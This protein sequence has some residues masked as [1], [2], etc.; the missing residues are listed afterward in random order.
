[1]RKHFHMIGSLAGIALVSAAVAAHA[2]TPANDPSARLKQV[3]P[4]DV[5]TRVLAVIAKAK[6]VELPTEALENRALKFA[7]KGVNGDSIAKSVADQEE[8]MEHVR[9]TLQ[10]ARGQKPS[11][12]EID[13]AAEAVRKGVDGSK[14]S[15]LAKSA[16]SGR[17]LVV[18]LYVIGSLVERGLPSDS[19][20][21]RVEAKLKARASDQ[22]LEKLPGELPA[23]ANASHGN[24]PAE[25]GRALAE[26][27]RPGSASGAGQSGGSAGGPPAGVPAN[28]G[29]K[30]ATPPGLGH[31]PTTP[32]PKKP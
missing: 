24:Q 25:T 5:A 11:G 6:S 1:M 19:A 20:L 16:P 3:L 7:A 30:P 26:T 32:P 31:K 4:P 17:S 14:V 13:A 8:R 29:G 10:H 22:D 18:P 12:D 23:Q 28:G 21:A 9:D 2:Q 27:K 15:A